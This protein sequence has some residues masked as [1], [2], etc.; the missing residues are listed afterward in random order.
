M[1]PWVFSFNPRYPARI[2]MG[3]VDPGIQV[4]GHTCMIREFTPVIVGVGDGMNSV[5]ERL[6]VCPEGVSNGSSGPARH[7]QERTVSFAL[8]STGVTS[9][10]AEASFGTNDD[11][12][13]VNRDRAGSA[14]STAMRREAPATSLLT[15]Q[16]AK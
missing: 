14:A 4:A 1:R 12:T 8:R 11:R 7:G 2:G 5:L 15:V 6:E 9:P 16:A 13:A 3:N 10:A